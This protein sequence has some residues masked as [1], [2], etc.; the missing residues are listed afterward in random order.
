MICE[1][2]DYKAIKTLSKGHNDPLHPNNADTL[3]II[4]KVT[5]SY[6]KTERT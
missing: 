1:T 2:F 5:Y 4:K 6:N 3:N